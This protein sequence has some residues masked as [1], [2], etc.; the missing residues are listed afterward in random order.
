MNGT[1]VNANANSH[2]SLSRFQRRKRRTMQNG[3]PQHGFIN[4]N[5]ECVW[6]SVKNEP[7]LTYHLRIYSTGMQSFRQNWGIVFGRHRKNWMT[8]LMRLV[9]AAFLRL[10]YR[11]R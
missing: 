2:V 9:S 6:V 3:R 8:T 1:S 5:Y 11:Q 4:G 10:P 7:K